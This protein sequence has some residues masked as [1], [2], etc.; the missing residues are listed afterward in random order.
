MTRTVTLRLDDESYGFFRRCAEA[1]HRPLSNLIETAARRHLEASLEIDPEEMSA[2]RDDKN[3]V[4]RIRA[5]SRDASKR[6]GRM[7]G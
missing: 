2:I 5:G 3:L 1:D 7:I 4:R 6:R